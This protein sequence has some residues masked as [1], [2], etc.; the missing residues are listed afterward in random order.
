MSN[1]AQPKIKNIM[2]KKVLFFVFAALIVAACSSN[3]EQEEQVMTISQLLENAATLVDSTVTIEGTVLHVCAHGGSRVFLTDAAGMEIKVEASDELVQ[4]DATLEQTD[5]IVTGIVRELRID[6]AYLLEWEA[7][8]AADTMVVVEDAATAEASAEVTEEVE[9]AVMDNHP[10][11]PGKDDHATDPAS[12]IA[13]YREKIAA[14][15][16][17]Y[18]SE[19]WFEAKSFT[20][21]TVEQT[22]EAPVAE[23][24]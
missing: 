22:E 14:S 24:E 3:K 15:A 11:S 7:E 13:S 2:G 5:I 19:Y 9:E 8:L 20:V 4:F 1:Y 21:K 18:V 23:Q 16:N 12:R 17:G 6:E 10:H